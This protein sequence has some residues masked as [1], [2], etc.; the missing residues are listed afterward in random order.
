[1]KIEFALFR[2]IMKLSVERNILQPIKI[3]L[4]KLCE[5]PDNSTVQVFYDFLRKSEYYFVKIDEFKD[6]FAHLDA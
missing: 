3:Y 5:F 2:I 4:W 1:M 6:I